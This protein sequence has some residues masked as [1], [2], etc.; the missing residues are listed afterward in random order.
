M[1]I[2][3]GQKIAD[4]NP[5]CSGVNTIPKNSVGKW[6]LYPYTQC[7]V[8]VLVF[9]LTHNESPLHTFI[10]DHTLLIPLM[11]VCLSVAPGVIIRAFNE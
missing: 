4:H 1:N 2:L 9:M 3:S 5:K 8:S 11:H 7:I 6:F 10:H